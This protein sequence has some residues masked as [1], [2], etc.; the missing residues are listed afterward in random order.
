[1]GPLLVAHRTFVRVVLRLALPIIA[2]IKRQPPY[3][4]V[5]VL[6]MTYHAYAG[7]GEGSRNYTLGKSALIQI[8]RSSVTCII[9]RI[10]CTQP[11]SCNCSCMC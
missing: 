2:A 10:Y 4:L 7:E 11:D 1:M 6:L 3:Y 5:T 9:T 8:H